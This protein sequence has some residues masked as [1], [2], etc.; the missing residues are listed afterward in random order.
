MKLSVLILTHNRPQLFSRCLA[1]L[2]DQITPDVEVIVNNDSQD[3][4]EISHS[5]VTYHY[6]KFNNLSSTYEFVF[7]Q[8]RGEYVYFLEDDD[9]LTKDFL[10]TALDADL[11]A[12]NYFPTYSTKDLVNFLKLNTDNRPNLQQ[13]ITNINLE[14]LQLGQ[15]IFKRSSIANFDW[16][17]DN[18]V[19]NDIRLVMHAANNSDSI[20]TT[21]KVFYYQTV[22]GG[23]NI[24]F[25]GTVPSIAVTKSMDFMRT[26]QSS[27]LPEVETVFFDWPITMWCNYKCSYCPV[28]EDVTNDF[29]KDKHTNM[30]KLTLSRLSKVDKPFNIC[31]TGGEPTLHPEFLDI[32][33]GLIN[34]PNCQNVSV[35]TNLSRPP[36]FFEKI[37]SSDKLVIIA[38][39]HPEYATSKFLERCIT[40]NQSSLN[41][42]VHLTLSD[43][44]EHWDQTETLLKALRE[45]NIIHKPLLLSRTQHYTPIYD[46][47]FSKRFDYYLETAGT[48]YSG[49]E[50]FKDIPVTY[51]DGSSE[52]LK[53]YDMERRG[54]NKFKG[55]KC[56]TVSY[57]I[58]MDGVIGNTC[59][60]RKVS[61]S[62]K[63]LIVTETCP[64]D[65]C[66]GRRLQQFYKTL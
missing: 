13:F 51:T 35:F 19:H 40:L 57:A 34:I 58:G 17:T 6:Q 5:Q 66:P 7:N 4:T 31:L 39:Y 61:M 54:L 46:D 50:H 27:G 11:I 28:V 25:E 24:S 37:H 12:G 65:A 62:L 49:N 9:Y 14:D 33:D 29:T 52:L 10:D 26:I 53:D 63:D 30:H 1:S 3:I 56:N 32:V 44:S 15:H 47:E 55:Y 22:D 21:R 36:K 38:S 64:H 18:N 59:T 48:N 2:L 23:D 8:A 41:F 45:H 43:K 16:G 60:Q 42:S 20:R